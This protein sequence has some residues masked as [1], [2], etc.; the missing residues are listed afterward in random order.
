MLLMLART[1]L[2]GSPFLTGTHHCPWIISRH[3]SLYFRLSRYLSALSEISP[4]CQLSNKS[5]QE[6]TL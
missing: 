4:L 2:E 6:V 3:F 1:K 5:E